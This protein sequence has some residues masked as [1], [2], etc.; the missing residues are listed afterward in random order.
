[1]SDHNRDN[2]LKGKFEG[3]PDH[4]MGENHPHDERPDVSRLE[5]MTPAP[6]DGILTR[7][8]LMFARA[9]EATGEGTSLVCLQ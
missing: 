9:P 6:A 1:M 3:L 2:R 8:R 5:S 4:L 7:S